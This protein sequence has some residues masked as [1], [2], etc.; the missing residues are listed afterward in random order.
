MARLVS[1]QRKR[2]ATRT[3]ILPIQCGT[4]ILT[5]HVVRYVHPNSNSNP[6]ILTLT[7]TLKRQKLASY[8]RSAQH[9]HNTAVRLTLL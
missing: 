5:I 1:A 6:D 2:G 3:Y 7:A 4:G 8:R 9:V